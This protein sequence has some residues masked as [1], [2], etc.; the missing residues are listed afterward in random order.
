MTDPPTFDLQ[1]HSTHSDGELAPGEL[2][3]RA[4]G[5]GVETLALTDHDTVDGV[6]EAIA[7]GAAHGVH[8]VPA[9]E[10]SAVAADQEDL[11]VLGYGIDH[12]DDAFLAALADLRLDRQRRIDA[13]AARLVGLGFVLESAELD[14]RARTGRV[15]GRPHVARAVLE[16]PA[17]AQRLAEEGATDPAAFFPRYLVPGAP[18]YVRRKRPT[19]SEAIALIHR[20]GG[21]A[22][23]AHP[24]WDIDDPDV[25]L[26]TVDVFRGEGLDG[27]EAFYAR[28]SREQ[29]LLLVEH[30]RASGLLTTGSAD[31][32]GPD[33]AI[34]SRFRAFDLH[35][36]SPDLG[37]IAG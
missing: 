21:V 7:A 30:A 25:V 2:V 8:V 10:L 35:G 29:T 11:H 31:F 14:R 26:A 9:L 1:A 34:F 3:A 16:H 24:F 22:V 27:V 19:V 6:E 13:M 5:A 4:A 18:A 15:I 17:N 32:H 33:H 20:A 28:H 36:E 23:W 12:R 37:P